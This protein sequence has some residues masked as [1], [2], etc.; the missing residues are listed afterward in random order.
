MLHCAYEVK[1]KEAAEKQLNKLHLPGIYTVSIVLVKLQN[2]E[3]ILACAATPVLSALLLQSRHKVSPML[4][5]E[6][7]IISHCSSGQ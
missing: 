3:H 4:L 1:R 7:H 5:Q 6:T 2:K